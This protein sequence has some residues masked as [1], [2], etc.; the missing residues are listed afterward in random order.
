[1]RS[2]SRS[3]SNKKSNSQN[4][5]QTAKDLSFNLIH[6]K[7][8]NKM[9]GPNATNSHLTTHRAEL[10]ASAQAAIAA[11]GD[12]ATLNL[13]DIFG[14][15][16]FTPDGDTVFLNEQAGR[17]RALNSGEGEAV[18]MG[19]S[20][21]TATGFA[22]VPQGGGLA[23][24]QLGKTGL[25]ALVMGTAAAGTSPSSHVPFKHKPQAEHHLEY[26]AAKKK[27]KISAGA[28]GIP[29]GDR[30]MSEQQKVERR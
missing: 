15:V 10:S 16:V 1:M 7:R 17:G 2:R 4:S 28:S 3:T 21:A 29:G 5:K 20:K 27:Q 14:D 13:D 23:T 18:K 11:K 22:A 9:T 6:H 8:N 12:P 26:V 30:K 25:P 24:T 19:A